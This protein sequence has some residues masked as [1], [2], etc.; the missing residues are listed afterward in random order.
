MLLDGYQGQDL[1]LFARGTFKVIS[2]ENQTC[3]HG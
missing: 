1:K 3:L 2:S